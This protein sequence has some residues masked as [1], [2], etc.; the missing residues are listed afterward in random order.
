MKTAPKIRIFLWSA[1]QNTLLS[2]AN[3]F[4]RHIIADPLCKLC[5][6]QTPETLEHLFLSCSSTRNISTH[7]QIKI[8]L[9]PH[10]IHRLDDYSKPLTNSR[11][12]SQRSLADLATA[13]C[14]HLS[15]STSGPDPSSGS[16][17]YTKSSSSDL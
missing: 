4:H 2:R 15:Q 10:M 17:N 6:Q 7:S 14:L 8:D 11:I 13:Q 16:Y 9:Q 5:N 12:S 3:L 1:C